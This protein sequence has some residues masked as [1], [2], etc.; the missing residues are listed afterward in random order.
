MADIEIKC[1]KCSKVVMVSE[2]AD[3]D[4]IVCHFC[5]EKLQKPETVS[6]KPKPTL[7]SLKIQEP[8]PLVG[9]KTDVVSEKWRFLKHAGKEKK[10]DRRFRMT[11]HLA[12]WIIFIVLGGIMG[13]LR[14]EGRYSAAFMGYSKVYGSFVVI[15]FHILIVLKA[16]KDSMFQGMLCLLVPLYSFYYLFAVSDD[17]YMR[18]VFG[19][20]LVGIAQDSVMVFQN[21]MIRAYDIISNWIASGGGG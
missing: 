2:F 18:A 21:Y 17:F 13:F 20:V 15:A 6:T 9:D 4:S 16:F 5:G 12:G 11:Y 1:P 3:P 14:Y 8:V 10:A 19:G 7:R